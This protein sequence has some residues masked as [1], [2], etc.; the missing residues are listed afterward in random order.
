MNDEE[1]P[2]KKILVL[3]NYGVGKT[4]L[5]KQCINED[6][7]DQYLTTLGTNIAL[8]DISIRFGGEKADVDV[9]LELW[10]IA[11]NKTIADV[12]REF[13]K[14]ANGA[15]IVADLS[16]E[17]SVDECENWIK[18]TYQIIDKIPFIFVGNKYDLISKEDIDMEKIQ[19]LASKYNTHFI[20]TSAKFGDNSNEAFHEIAERVS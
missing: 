2:K 20:L 13:Y 9:E 19:A 11:G 14:D 16:K 17:K 3:G 6:F 1:K 5:I 7:D 15:I 4:S 8:K 18:A 10:D 12:K